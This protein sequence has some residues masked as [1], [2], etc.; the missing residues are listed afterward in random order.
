M[1]KSKRAFEEGEVDN[2]FRVSASKL[3]NRSQSDLFLFHKEYY[4]Q[5]VVTSATM[6]TIGNVMRITLVES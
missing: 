1:Q 2:Q 4:K 6:H 5:G 3:F